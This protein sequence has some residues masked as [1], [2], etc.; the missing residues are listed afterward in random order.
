MITAL[1][2]SLYFRHFITVQLVIR[3]DE[4]T[5]RRYITGSVIL[6]CSRYLLEYQ[7]ES[8]VEC[9]TVERAHAVRGRRLLQGLLSLLPP[10]GFVLQR[11]L[12][13][14]LCLL[15][16]LQ[17]LLN[18]GWNGARQR[19]T[20]EW[21]MQN[22]VKLNI[23]WRIKISLYKIKYWLRLNKLLRGIAAN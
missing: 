18:D 1:D 6:L 15:L 20:H 7:N 11:F 14:P 23:R 3:D 5:D 12:E 8:E 9:L 2:K 13:F 10:L 22:H 17:T 16:F 19:V 21:K 4:T